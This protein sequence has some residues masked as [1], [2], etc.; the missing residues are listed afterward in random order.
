MSYQCL[1]RMP[2]QDF[3]RSK[4]D[5]LCLNNILEVLAGFQRSSISIW[6]SQQ[7]FRGLGRS[8]WDIYIRGLSR[9][10]EVFCK[11]QWDLIG[12]SQ[13]GLVGFW[14][15]QQGLEGLNRILA[16][17]SRGLEVLVGFWRSQ[18]YQQD[19]VGLQRLYMFVLVLE[20]QMS[21]LGF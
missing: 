16:G 21:Y 10:I 19:L 14:R 20:F 6:R 3:K 7:G 12:S 2:Q 9:N 4:Q 11:N 13:Q 15:S 5:L 8:Q 1:R 17:F 18:Q